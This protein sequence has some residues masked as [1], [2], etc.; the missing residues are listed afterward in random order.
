MTAADEQCDGVLQRLAAFLRQCLDGD[1]PSQVVD[2][3]ERHLPG[4]GVGLGRGGTN[5]ERA[6]EAW[7]DGHG[8][9]VRALADA[10]L[11]LQAAHR[12]PH[13][14]LHGLQVG[15]AGDLRDHATEAGV[16]FHGAG[17]LVDEFLDDRG[18][19]VCLL[20]TVGFAHAYDA[21]TGL[22]AGT[23]DT[24]DEHGLCG[25]GS[26]PVRGG[27][28]STR[29]LGPIFRLAWAL[30]VG[31]EHGE[32]IGPGRLVVA[33]A[34]AG[35]LEAIAFVEPHGRGVAVANLEVH[36]PADDLE[37]LEELV[38]QQP[39]VTLALLLRGQRHGMD[40]P[41][42]VRS[43]AVERDACIA[44]QLTGHPQGD[45]VVTGVSQLGAEDV[46]GPGGFFAEQLLLDPRHRLQ[47]GQG[48]AIQSQQLHCG[49]GVRGFDIRRFSIRGFG[50]CRFRVR[51]LGDSTRCVGLRLF[52]RGLRRPLLSLQPIESRNV[53]S[54]RGEVHRGGALLALRLRSIRPAQVLRHQRATQP[55]REVSLPLE[56]P[57]LIRARQRQPFGRGIRVL[58]DDAPSLGR[59]LLLPLKLLDRAR[60][61]GGQRHRDGFGSVLGQHV[62]GLAHGWPSD[63]PTVLG[64]GGGVPLAPPGVGKNEAFLV[65]SRNAGGGG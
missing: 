43:R 18:A 10:G 21:N 49:L 31:A 12:C 25:I 8:D 13:G 52:Q 62:R 55:L 30:L 27:V 65:T 24:H 50:V 3:V 14:G 5:H 51:R 59:S 16:L 47:V 7:P 61:L 28:P 41:L 45:V 57:Q 37:G 4:G 58:R 6:G 20:V 17:D 33:L 60:H 15:A 22:V 46:Q 23:F 39:R 34:P 2:R 38:H 1:V 32:R 19:P 26:A 44:L 53:L 64:G 48:C 54:G 9:G 56:P 42:R 29:I 11:L 40:F 35:D 36:R 63:Q